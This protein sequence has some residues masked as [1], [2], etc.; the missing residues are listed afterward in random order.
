MSR[1]SFSQRMGL[2]PKEFPLQVDSL[3]R[4]TRIDIWNVFYRYFD[5]LTSCKNITFLET[6]DRYLWEV[7]WA[8]F[9]E[10]ELD[11]LYDLVA[12][13]NIIKS[14]ILNDQTPWNRVLDFCEFLVQLPIQKTKKLGNL[15]NL[16]FEKHNVAFRVIGT[17]IAPITNDQ[18][19]QAIKTAMELPDKLS[20]ARTHISAALRLLS[21]RENP[22]YRNSIKESIS[23]VEAVCMVLVGDESASLGNALRHLE[24]NGI[25]I[26]PALK[27]GFSSIYGYTSD[28]GGI[29]HAMIEEGSVVSLEDALFMLVSCSAFCHYLQQKGIQAGIFS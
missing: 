9:F 25:K 29:R 22:D 2:A 26:H 18:E 6:D 11:N 4:A 21:D 17:E 1:S 13:D 15:F 24:N 14:F 12:L 7:I 3:D 8:N 28:Q 27:S 19:I 20:G 10:K 5:L 16:V 23:A